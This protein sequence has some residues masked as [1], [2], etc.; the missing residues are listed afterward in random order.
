MPVK[1]VPDAY[2][3]V[4]PYLIVNGAKDAIEFYK[5]AFGATEHGMI[6]LPDGKIAHAEVKI[7][8]TVVRLCDDLPMFE[9]QAPSALGGTTVEIFLFVEDVDATVRKAEHAGATV[10]THADEPILGR[11]NERPD[12]SVRP[13]LADRDARRGSLTPGDRRAGQGAFSAP[14]R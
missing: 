10:K 7:G 6:A 14:A 1:P 11:T 13:R 4:A 12:R 9:G 8:D 3:S 5:D 2:T